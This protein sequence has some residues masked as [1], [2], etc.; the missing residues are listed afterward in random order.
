MWSN[1]PW[2]IRTVQIDIIQKVHLT[3]CPFGQSKLMYYRLSI[4]LS[5]IWTVQIYVTDGP[6]DRLQFGWSVAV[7]LD[8]PIGRHQTIHLD[9]QFKH[10][11]TIQ[12]YIPESSKLTVHVCV[13]GWSKYMVSRRSFGRQ[14]GR[15]S[16]V[17]MDN[18]CSYIWMVPNQLYSDIQMDGSG[19]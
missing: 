16:I 8:R 10:I 2:S 4:G 1:G 3:F 12:L 11:W 18:A 15:L 9:G 13:F 14:F 19:T 6:L 17:Q 5:F 7:Y